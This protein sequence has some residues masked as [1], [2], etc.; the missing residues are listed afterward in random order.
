MKPENFL[1][2]DKSQEA[3]LKVLVGILVGL[4]GANVGLSHWSD[5][6]HSFSHNHGSAKYLHLK[7]NYFWR[8]PFWTPIIV[9]GVLFAAA[10]IPVA[11]ADHRLWLGMSL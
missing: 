9:Y 8:D 5:T 2:H 4:D 6:A 3:L 10:K 1:F 11:P 7:G